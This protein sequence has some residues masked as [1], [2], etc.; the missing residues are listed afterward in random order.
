MSD[1]ADLIAGDALKASAQRFLAEVRAKVD[2]QQGGLL[3]IFDS[4]FSRVLTKL[5]RLDRERPWEESVNAHAAGISGP[6]PDLQWDLKRLRLFLDRWEQ[7]RFVEFSR[8]ERSAVHY[9]SRFGT[10][11]GA[12]VLLTCQ[13]APSLMRWRGKPLMKNVFDFAIYPA[14][15]AELR[16]RTIF[17]IG[18]Q[19]AVR[20]GPPTARACSSSIPCCA[21]LQ[22]SLG[23][24]QARTSRPFPSW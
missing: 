22:T 12:D 23:A 24:S 6:A 11:F 3:S 14:L 17:E 18:A 2:Q 7:G 16:P 1:A 8:R 13:G 20:L 19:S 9:H 21:Q 10:E 15:I 4:W 5:S